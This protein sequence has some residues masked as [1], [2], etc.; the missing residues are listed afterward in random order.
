MMLIMFY[1]TKISR[2]QILVGVKDFDLPLPYLS[3]RPPERISGYASSLHSTNAA[4]RLGECFVQTRVLLNAC[5][6]VVCRIEGFYK[7]TAF[8]C[9][10]CLV[11]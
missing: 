1:F 4:L 3:P 9:Q 10:L 6:P 7:Q 8:L 2:N 5:T 11:M